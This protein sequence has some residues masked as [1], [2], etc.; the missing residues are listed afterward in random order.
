M[1]NI[2]P[3]GEW[4]SLGQIGQYMVRAD[5]DF[6]ARTY[7]SARLSDLVKRLTQRFDF[8][9]DVPLIVLGCRLYEIT[10]GIDDRIHG[11][12]LVASAVRH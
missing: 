9:L 3:D 7:G 10:D 2:D 11:S 4:F 1:T 6:D 8:R 5:P 12:V